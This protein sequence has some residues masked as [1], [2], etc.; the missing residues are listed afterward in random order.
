[1]RPARIPFRLP[2]VLLGC[3]I[4]PSLATAQ[5]F[6]RGPRVRSI[7]GSFGDGGPA[8]TV[9]ISAGYRFTPRL[10]LEVDTSYMPGLDFGDV[11][12]CP[13][14]QRLRRRRPLGAGYRGHVLNAGPGRF[15][16]GQ[17]GLGAS[18]GYA[19]NPAV[20]RRRGGYR[21]VRREL[22][23]N[24]PCPC[25]RRRVRRARWSPW[26]AAWTFF[27]WRGI[28]VGVNLRYQHVFEEDQF[29]RPD[30]HRDMSRTRLGSSVSYRF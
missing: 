9:G 25:A 22:Q 6:E 2:A 18:A 28:A 27:V 20:C 19:T 26:A 13:P 12:A 14:W 5:P 8:P 3:L 1:M 15:A 23:H 30:I 29:G 4:V 11:P 10:A 24:F 7:S 21:T 17:R 16:L